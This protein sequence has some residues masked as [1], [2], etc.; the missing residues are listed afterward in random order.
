MFF[1]FQFKILVM[2]RNLLGCYLGQD[3][4]H[5]RT[6][7]SLFCHASKVILPFEAGKFTPIEDATILRE[8]QETG[9]TN[10]IWRKLATILN[11]SYNVI[12]F[13]YYQNLLNRHVRKGGWSLEEEAFFLEHFFVGTKHSSRKIIDSINL[14]NLETVAQELNRPIFC[15]NFHWK[16]KLK[17][18]LLSYH[19]ESLFIDN[20]SEFYHYLIEKRVTA[21]QDIDWKEATR[22]FPTE[23]SVSLKVAV[24][25]EI[26]KANR[27]NPSLKFE[28]IY[29]KL[30]FVR[31]DWINA[32]LSEKVKKYRE[33]IV[34]LYD[35]IRGVQT[36]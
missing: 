26:G 1:S 11:R 7:S 25:N 9:D 22:L 17:P 8:V 18:V 14:K 15:V 30:E 21:L 31:H 36:N 28:P 27:I 3:L 34:Q 2:K 4:P 29:V 13:R 6:G 20:Y 35:E 12:K 10:E 24:R 32:Q 16:H 23:N 5:V 33:K 19:N